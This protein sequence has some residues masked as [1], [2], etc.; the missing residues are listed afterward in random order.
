MQVH[1]NKIEGNDFVASPQSLPDW[2]KVR[3]EYEAGGTSIRA[4]AKR[5]GVSHPAII[6]R[7]KAEGWVTAPHSYQQPK[8]SYQGGNSKL[9]AVVTSGVV[10]STKQERKAARKAKA[11]AE[12]QEWFAADRKQRELESDKEELEWERDNPLEDYSHSNRDAIPHDTIPLSVFRNA[13]GHVSIFQPKAD[14]EDDAAVGRDMWR[15]RSKDY[16]VGGKRT[17]GRNEDKVVQVD[18]RCIPE[19]I[20]RLQGIMREA[21]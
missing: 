9:E 7:A 15:R 19:L 20:A 17:N 1:Q 10:T 4:I 11:D 3:A 6:K 13:E 14:G 5:N 16:G 18:L 2:L 12:W 8:S 21:A